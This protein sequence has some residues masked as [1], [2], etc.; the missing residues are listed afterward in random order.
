MLVRRENMS[1]KTG[2]IIILLLVYVTCFFG[3][4]YGSGFA[5]FTQGAK[6]LGQAASSIAHADDASTIFYNP[7]IINKLGGTRVEVGTTLLYISRE[8]TSD[9]SGRTFKT[10]SE[11]HFPS[12][13]FATHK[14]NDTI[15]LGLGVF[16]PFGL[17]TDWGNNWEGRYLATNSEMLTVNVNPVVSFRLTP[18]ISFAAGVSYL[19]LD[20]TLEKNLN[21]STLALPD[22]GQDFS[23]DGDG[24]G[25][26]VGLLVDP[27]KD[28]SVGLSFRSEIDVDIDGDVSHSLPPGT[29]PILG[30]VFPNTRA[31]SNIVLPAQFNAGVFYRG[32]DPLT[33]EVG[34]R[35]EGWSSYDELKIDLVQPVAG[36]TS[37]VIPKKWDDVFSFLI[38]GQYRINDMYTLNAGYLYS[39]NPVPDETFEPAIPDSD[40]HLFT[41]GTGIKYR[42]W[43]ID[44]AYGYQFF[45]DRDKVNLLD[46][47]PLDGLTNAAATANGG[48]DSDIHMVGLSVSFAF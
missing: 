47:N 44:L 15:S 23:G 48:Y 30:P 33:F 37:N 31:D 32:F 4:S 34:I 7:A 1:R 28:F 9:F 25:F 12:T 5:I 18:H 41:L 16:S 14:L 17:S 39:D 8:F 20:A 35:W 19:Y 6:P 42:N 40:V 2:S 45:D 22:A 13:F 24:V 21:L 46:D 3:T 27:H 36:M 11:A 38:G 26:N 29:A 10:E 43:N